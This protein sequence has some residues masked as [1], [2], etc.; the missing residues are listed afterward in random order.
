MDNNEQSQ[1]WNA[2]NRNTFTYLT[3]TLERHPSLE[4]VVLGVNGERKEQTMKTIQRINTLSYI[5]AEHSKQTIDY[6]FSQ[7]P[8]DITNMLNLIPET[9]EYVRRRSA[10]ID[11]IHRSPSSHEVHF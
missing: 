4:P 9:T 11:L 1:F 10:K 3:E 5:R 6:L 8:A 2:Y 7:N